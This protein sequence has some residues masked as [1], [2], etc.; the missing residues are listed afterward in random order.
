MNKI[1]VYPDPKLNLG[2]G[3]GVPKVLV[4]KRLPGNICVTI[5]RL[6]VIRRNE[7]NPTS[8]LTIM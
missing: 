4:R 8:T 1:A 6:N 2:L 3:G 7:G 5:S